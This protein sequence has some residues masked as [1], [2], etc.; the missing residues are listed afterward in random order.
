MPPIAPKIDYNFTL[1]NQQITD[2][3]AWLRDPNWPNV[4]DKKIIEYLEAENNYA[5]QFFNPLQAEKDKIF[6]EIKGRIK[7]TDQSVP[8]KK[9]DYYYYIRTEQ[10]KGY[11]IY[12]RKKYSMSAEEEI[13]LDVN[14]IAQNNKFTT[15]RTIA[16]SPDH[17]LMAYSVNFTGDEKFTIK[18]YNLTT[19][20]YL[21]DAIP[22]VGGNIIWHEKLKGFF[23]LP[24]NQHFRQDKLMFHTLGAR[25][26]NDQLIFSIHDPLYQIDANKS[27][28]KQYVFINVAGHNTNEIHA[29]QMDDEHFQPQLIRPLKEGI[30]Y[31]VEHNGNNF[32]IRTNEG[33]KN[34]R[35]VLVDINNFQNSLWENNYV[36]EAPNRYLISCEITK[37]YLILNYRVLGL[38]LSKIKHL[39]NET[40]KV[41]NFPDAAFSAMALSTNFDE[42]DIRVV[43]S[44][45]A[46]PNTTYSY[47]FNDEKLSI[48]K[49]QE[50]PSG[51]NPDEYMV[52]RIFADNEGVQVPIS[53][54]YKK[55]LFKKD[56]S[57]PLYLY[58]YGSYG[59][60]LP[61]AFSN[62]PISLVNRG[63]VYAIAHIRGGNELGLDWYEAAKFLN[64]KRTFSDFIAAAEILINQKYTSTGNIAICGGSAGG[65]LMGGV[66]NLRPEL[67][68]AVIA[69]VP[70][71]D[72]L[73]TMLDE[74]LPLTPGEFKEWGNP[75]ELEYFN[76]IKSYSPYDNIK[77]QNYPS[78]FITAGL[79]DPRVGYWEPAKWA[80]RLRAMKTDNNILLLKT[81]MDTGHQGSSD[82]FDYLKEAADDI[83]FI[84]KIFNI[85]T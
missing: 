46:R 51:F 16:I 75:K 56:G 57:N 21:A 39:T 64:K 11:P 20:E 10:D 68:K 80:A 59:I 23:Y 76:Y 28:S 30:F 42:D 55:S 7:L 44:S 17:T 25:Q 74:S 79:S 78:L 72:V 85:N 1:H 9:D 47:D 71:V 37:N 13:I 60:G 18:I 22:N 82:R 70:F 19:K 84:L 26:E 54:W 8:T 24:L 14:L 43:Y 3:Y 32:Y 5:A 2:E 34:F 61:A 53:L 4:Q 48:L 66:M 36:P 35:V 15:V 6:E 52:E 40:E 33:A 45:P 41:I 81:N 38:A 50:I 62:S 63:F 12:C 49:T 27:S 65:L 29:I 58:G 67:F 83:V 73:S 69:H 77:A 31:D